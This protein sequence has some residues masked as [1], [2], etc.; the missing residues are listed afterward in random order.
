MPGTFLKNWI[1][2][3]LVQEL[4]HFTPLKTKCLPGFTVSAWKKT[5]CLISGLKYNRKDSA[6]FRFGV[7]VDIIRPGLDR[8]WE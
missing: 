5:P 3:R 1:K 4:P 8:L 6:A 2:C 7:E